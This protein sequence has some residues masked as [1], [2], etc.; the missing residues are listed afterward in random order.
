MKDTLKYTVLPIIIF[1]LIWCFLSI[2]V[3]HALRVMLDDY[4]EKNVTV[5]DCPCM[6]EVEE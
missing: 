6:F 3:L 1:M 2:G 4:I 5:C